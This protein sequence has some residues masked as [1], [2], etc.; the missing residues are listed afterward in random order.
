MRTPVRSSLRLHPESSEAAGD[1]LVL[2]RRNTWLAA[3]DEVSLPYHP[4]V[5]A[6]EGNLQAVAERAR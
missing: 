2:L 1:G 3:D 5:P 6:I 4:L